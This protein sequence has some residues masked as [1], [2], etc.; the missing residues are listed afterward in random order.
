MRAVAAPICS[1]RTLDA[2]A[3]EHV[4]PSAAASVRAPRSTGA[5]ARTGSPSRPWIASTSRHDASVSAWK[6]ETEAPALL[7][8][9]G[10]EQRRQQHHDRDRER[11]RRAE[12]G[13]KRPDERDPGARCR[14]PGDRQVRSRAG[15][16][17][18]AQPAATPPSAARR[19]RTSAARP[20][21]RKARSG[22]AV[23]DCS[24]A[25][26]GSHR[27]AGLRPL[28]LSAGR[29]KAGARDSAPA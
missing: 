25:V 18:P 5:S 11:G 29:C 27:A 2:H 13:R 19:A 6:S 24:S 20:A 15:R 17:R 10:R 1:R 3:R 12:Q 8:R 21:A 16:G 14:G 23:S 9:K 28:G 22:F 7:E 26:I 4:S